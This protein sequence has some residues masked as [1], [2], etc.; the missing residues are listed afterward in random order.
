MNARERDAA[1]AIN[2]MPAEQQRTLR[3]SFQRSLDGCYAL[4]EALEQH[5]ANSNALASDHALALS[6]IATLRVMAIRMSA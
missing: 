2:A 4:A 3:R 5:A 6:A 1:R